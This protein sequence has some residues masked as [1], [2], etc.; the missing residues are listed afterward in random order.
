MEL[1]HGGKV[2]N[3]ETSEQLWYWSNGGLIRT[4]EQSLYRSPKESLFW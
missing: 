3:T 4:I 2:Y 1:V